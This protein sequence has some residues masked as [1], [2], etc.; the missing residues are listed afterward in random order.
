[1]TPK[2]IYFSILITLMVMV[3][4]GFYASWWYDHYSNL[5]KWRER[6]LTC[7]DLDHAIMMHKVAF[8]GVLMA[9]LAVVIYTWAVA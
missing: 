2:A 4:G 9:L 1:M 7:R 6:Y 5:K 8:F 3:A